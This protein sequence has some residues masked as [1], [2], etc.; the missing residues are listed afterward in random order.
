MYLNESELL[1]KKKIG[2]VGKKAVFGIGNIGGLHLIA[3]QNDDGSLTTLGA[4][5]HKGVARHIA[6]KYAPTIEYDMLEKS[7]D[8]FHVSDFAEILPFW[9]S[10][11]QKL[12]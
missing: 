4:G 12:K 6:K 9:E 8:G 1:Y 2:K 3:Q 5:S 11:T 10:V 7:D